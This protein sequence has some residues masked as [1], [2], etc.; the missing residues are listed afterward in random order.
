MEEAIAT[1]WIVTLVIVLILTPVV[2]Y[3]CWRL[4]RGAR[5]IEH[6]FEVTLKAAT[7][8]AA[9]TAAIPAL[10]DTITVAGGML[11]TAG[12]IDQHSGAIAGLL[13]AR[14]REGA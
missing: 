4:V 11:Q 7:G 3:L 10:Q 14:L 2:L 8:V 6:H 5:N 13:A 9:G 12:S 1:V